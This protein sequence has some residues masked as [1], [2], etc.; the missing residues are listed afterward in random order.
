MAFSDI[1]RDLSLVLAIA[2]LAAALFIR[3]RLSSA[4]A[5]LIAQFM[6]GQDY[7]GMNTSD[8]NPGDPAMMLGVPVEQ[9]RR[10]YIFL[11]PDTYVLNYVNVTAP[12]G[13]QATLV[14]TMT[15]KQAEKLGGRDQT[16]VGGL[17][18]P[19]KQ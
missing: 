9:Y 18:F 11:A 1:M 8:N 19:P 14:F 10:S 3:L 4:A 16:L 7:E 2:T 13:E 6:V 17:A 5:F 12:T 15:P